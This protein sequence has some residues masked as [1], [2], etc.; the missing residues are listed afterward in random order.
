MS[1]WFTLSVIL[2]MHN[3]QAFGGWRLWCFLC[4]K[5][6]EGLLVVLFWGI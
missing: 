1:A 4:L 3:V 6:D 2:V 5:R